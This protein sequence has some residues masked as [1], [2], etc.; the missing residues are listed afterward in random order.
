MK[1]DYESRIK[2]EDLEGNRMRAQ[3][4]KFELRIST[5][6]KDLEQKAKE[7]VQLSHLCDDLIKGQR[8]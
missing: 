3:I 2:T 8:N 7:N 6:E 1:N 5:I 4:R